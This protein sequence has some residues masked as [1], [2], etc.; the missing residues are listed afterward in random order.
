MCTAVLTLACA[1]AWPGTAV[2]KWVDEKG[3]THY[4][5]QPHADAKQ[6]ELKA[7]QTYQSDAS[8]SAP[9][10]SAPAATLPGQAYS[11]CEISRPENDEVFLNTATVPARLR[12]TPV[13]RSGDRIAIG[14]D[15]KPQT[16][17]PA[18]ATDFV[19]TDVARGTHTL[20]ATV[21]DADGKTVC[22]SRSV[23]FHVRQPSVQAPNPANRPRF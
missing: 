6:V 2:Y 3:V 19:L 16:N 12:L 8:A 21:Q 10:G 5:D 7:A 1:S 13:L 17:Q 14:L 18:S 15:G 9:T 11:A 23:T 4:S 22:A 20:M